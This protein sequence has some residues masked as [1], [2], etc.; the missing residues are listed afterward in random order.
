MKIFSSLR[1]L[2]RNPLSQAETDHERILG[3]MRDPLSHPDIEQMDARQ[4][5]DLPL[6]RGF[7][8]AQADLRD[9]RI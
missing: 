3:W 9:C 5:G 4:L 8:R 7:R 1:T 6:N 2:V